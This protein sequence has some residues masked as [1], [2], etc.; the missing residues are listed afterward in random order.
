MKLDGRLI[1]RKFTS[2]PVRVTAADWGAAA[3]GDEPSHTVQIA[4][5]D[6]NGTLLIESATVQFYARRATVGGAK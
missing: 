1:N 4:V 6:Q 3:R 5:V 2:S